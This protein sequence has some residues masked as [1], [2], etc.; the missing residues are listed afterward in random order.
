VEPIVIL[1]AP[2]SGSSMTAGLFAKHGAW[3]GP[4]MPGNKRNEKGYFES[5]PFKRSLLENCGRLVESGDVANPV[6]GWREIAERILSDNGYTGGPW[7]VKHSALYY[8]VWHE[9]S[10]RFICV[11]RSDQ[12]LRASEEA[13]GM[14]ANIE[15][16]KAVMDAVGGVDVFTD[17]IVAGD[18]SSLERAFDFCDIRMDRAIVDDFVEPS[19]WHYAPS[20]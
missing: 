13:T 17:D 8:P 7:L 5:I 2:R 3:V 9:F 11:R 12:G 20:S 16:H 19:L 6:P 4:C 1:A 14:I 10:P 15:A 18:F